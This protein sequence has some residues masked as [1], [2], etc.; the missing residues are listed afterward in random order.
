MHSNNAIEKH[1]NRFFTTFDND[2]LTGFVIV[3]HPPFLTT[4]PEKALFPKEPS[5]ILEHS[6]RKL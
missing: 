2:L 1:S 4:Q 3:I 6:G 5:E